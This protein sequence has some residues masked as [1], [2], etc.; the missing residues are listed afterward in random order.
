MRATCP[1]NLIL[2]ALSTLIILGEAYKLRSSQLCT[3]IKP[4]SSTYSPQPFVLPLVCEISFHAHTKQ[5][6]EL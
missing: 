3:H 2:L 5:Q 1:A 6:V 4:L